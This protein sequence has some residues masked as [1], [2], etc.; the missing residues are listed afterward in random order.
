MS[1]SRKKVSFLVG[2]QSKPI[3]I[4]VSFV[5]TSGPSILV[6]VP[7]FGGNNSLC[8]PLETLL[9]VASFLQVVPTAQA[10]LS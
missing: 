2:K 10:F 8:L 9:L 5:G 6:I 4:F 7:Y 1:C 3:F